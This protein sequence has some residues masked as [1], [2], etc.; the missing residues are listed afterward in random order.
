[1]F[2]VNCPE[3]Q[4]LITAEA[5]SELNAENQ[6][7]LRRH[8]E[9]CAACRTELMLERATKDILRTLLGFRP[10][11]EALRG[12]I[13]A[14]LA[15]EDSAGRHWWHFGRTPGSR[16]GL[17]LTI[18]GVVAASACI[19]L[20]VIPVHHRHSHAQPADGDMI[21]QTYNNFDNILQGT[22][23][24][25]VVSDNHQTLRD[26]LRDRVGF[27]VAIPRLRGCVL[28]GGSSTTYGNEPVVHLMYKHGGD[29]VYLYEADIK[30]VLNGRVL[31]LPPEAR[32]QL[33][34]NRWYA[35]NHA[36]DCSLIVWM[37]ESAVC[38]AVADIDREELFTTIHESQ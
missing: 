19:I 24:P 35:E 7:L 23:L 14:M 8:L 10:A 17:F 4:E 5:D 29:V 28:V 2:A 32:E 26:F 9:A 27:R 31:Y 6:I 36:P 3:F 25:Q 21:H 12:T 20:L 33:L 15:R 34:K 38:S 11:P 1:L 18:G 30:A 37:A 13:E 16:R 22:M